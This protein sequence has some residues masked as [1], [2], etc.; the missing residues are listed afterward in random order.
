MLQLFNFQLTEAKMKSKLILLV[1]IFCSSFALAQNTTVTGT[2]T[3]SDNI[4]W[5]NGTITFNLLGSGGPYFCSGTLMTPSQTSVTLNLNNTGAFSGSVCDNATITP[6]SSQWQMVIDP[7]GSAPAQTLLPTVITGASQNLT[8]YI[9]SNIKAIRIPIGV[10]TSVYADIEIVNPPIGGSYFNVTT[11]QTRTW[12]GIAW[13]NNSGNTLLNAS[14][15]PH[16]IAC[17]AK[18]KLNAGNCRVYAIGDSTTFGSWCIPSGTGNLTACSYPTRLSQFL[19]T[20]ILPAQRNSFMGDGGINETTGAN[21]ARVTLGSWTQSTIATT[22]GDLFTTTAAGA[23]LSFLPTDQVNTFRIWYTTNPGLGSFSWNIDG[24]GATTI[25]TNSAASITSATVP[26]GALGN[27]TLN[28]TYVSGSQVYVAG[29]E[30]YNSAIGSVQIVN[31]GWAGVTTHNI[32]VSGVSAWNPLQAVPTQAPDLILLDLGINDWRT[33]VLLSD[34]I[35]NM[36]IMITAWKI[37]SD[38]IIVTPAPSQI[39]NASLA[40]QQQFVSAMISLAATNNLPVIDN[41]NRWISWELKNPAPFLFYQNGLHPNST[42]YSDFAQ[43]IA[44]QL[45]NITG[46]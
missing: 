21:D 33:G 37:N 27:H 42:G 45:L 34:Y 10:N 40:T 4:A 12:N 23:P 1:F 19:N 9:G 36:Q 18:V 46:H 43:A 26:A 2:V 32:V 5:A 11:Y 6:V 44:S 16:W 7:Q 25:S 8:S 31:A 13:V 3:D 39:T 35:N 30:A 24:G 15:L 22:G 29:V 28:L 14:Q 17:T 38:I 41:F 20:T